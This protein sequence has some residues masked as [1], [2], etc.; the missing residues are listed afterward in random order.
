MIEDNYFQPTPTAAAR[1]ASI[2]GMVA[3]LQEAL[4]RQVLPL[5]RPPSSFEAVRGRDL[6][7]LQGHRAGRHR[8]PQGLR[9]SEV[10][11]DT[12]AEGAGIKRGDVISPSTGKSIAGLA[13]EVS[14]AL[15]KGPAGTDGDADGLARPTAA[16]RAS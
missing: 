5:L 7:P 4:R 3:A 10:F 8:G 1:D 15:I 9:V 12:P 14:T 13:A 11:P 2:D 6:G 16:S